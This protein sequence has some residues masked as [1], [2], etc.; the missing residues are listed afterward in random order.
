MDFTINNTKQKENSRV[1]S[2]KFVWNRN[3]I[4]IIFD[5]HYIKDKVQ[6]YQSLLIIGNKNL[7]DWYIHVKKIFIIKKKRFCWI[8]F[9]HTNIETSN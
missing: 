5:N 6:R 1:F 8:I 4:I 2:T 9:D 7:W 3:E